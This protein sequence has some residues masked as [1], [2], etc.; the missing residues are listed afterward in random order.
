MIR[1]PNGYSSSRYDASVFSTLKDHILSN[2]VHVA[3]EIACS[4]L[5]SFEKPFTVAAAGSPLF[6]SSSP[7]KQSFHE[8][9]Y[10]RAQLKKQNKLIDVTLIPPFPKSFFCFDCHSRNQHFH[11]EAIVTCEII[12]SPCFRDLLY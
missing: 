4:I 2:L 12:K 8:P 5:S 6:T 9:S 1:L 7:S 10:E 11:D 3:I